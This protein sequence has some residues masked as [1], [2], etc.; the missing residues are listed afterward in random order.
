MVRLTEGNFRANNAIRD[1]EIAKP[2]LGNARAPKRLSEVELRV[3]AVG[4]F[5]L[6]VAGHL[7]FQ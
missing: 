5:W 2:K 4:C 6:I 7:M 3:K 1:F